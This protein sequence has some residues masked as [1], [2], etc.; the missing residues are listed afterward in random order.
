MGVSWLPNF[1][2]LKYQF[3]ALKRTP[4]MLCEIS[5]LSFLL[6]SFFKI[7]MELYVKVTLLL[8]PFVY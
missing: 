4:E 5:I 1:L 3:L 7:V 6:Q 2:L 8:L